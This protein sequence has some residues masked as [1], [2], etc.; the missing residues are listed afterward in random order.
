MLV[1]AGALA[2]LPEKLAK[3]GVSSADQAVVLLED[4]LEGTIGEL[5]AEEDVTAADLELL[6]GAIEALR[7]TAFAGKRRRFD[8]DPRTADL[9]YCMEKEKAMRAAENKELLGTRPSTLSPDSV[10]PQV[11]GVGVSLSFLRKQ[12]SWKTTGGER[13]LAR[14]TSGNT[15]NGPA[16]PCHC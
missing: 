4:D 11:E 13:S 14:R 10:G 1:R 6:K 7:K 9:L 3:L 8:I 16:G 5:Y 15:P 2:T 12:R